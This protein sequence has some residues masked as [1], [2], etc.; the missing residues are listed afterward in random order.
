MS[1]NGVGWPDAK[2]GGADMAAFGRLPKSRD[3]IPKPFASAAM[4]STW[5]SSAGQ[6][7]ACD[8]Q[9]AG[10]RPWKKRCDDPERPCAVGGTG[11]RRQPLHGREM[12]AVAA[13]KPVGGVGSPGLSHHRPPPAAATRLR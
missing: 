11:N 8:F 4:N 10:V 1:N 13:A 12:G 9:V 5:I 2:H 3:C 6:P 7:T